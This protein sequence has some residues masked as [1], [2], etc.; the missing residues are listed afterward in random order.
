MKHC[1]HCGNKYN[2]ELLVCVVD[3][4]S[5][6]RS[7]PDAD[8]LTLSMSEDD[9]I[10]ELTT[11]LRT[12]AENKKEFAIKYVELDQQCGFASGDT[13]KHLEIAAEEAGLQI[14]RRG[15]AQASLRKRSQI[16]IA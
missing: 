9:K 4:A 11:T 7:D 14:V 13:K 16:Y 2:D 6:L 5:L 8:T 15:E 1:P 3:G 12:L 10:I